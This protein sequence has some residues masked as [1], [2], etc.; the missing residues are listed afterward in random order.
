MADPSD[1][2]D[3]AA[4][5]FVVAW[6]R[7]DEVPDGTERL[8]LFGV[9]RRV[10]ANQRRG[11]VRRNRLADRLRDELATL[12]RTTWHDETH[13]AVQEAMLRLPDGDR[14]LL[15]LAAWEGLTPAEIAILEGLPPATV[16]SRLLRA[17]G[18]LRELLREPVAA[19]MQRGS[20]DGHV[21]GGAP[22]NDPT[23]RS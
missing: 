18:R 10:L 23:N 1:A 15:Q 20:R 22:S 19:G 17:R 2:A 14:E 6:R 21:S 9:A 3:V 12:P 8:W 5:V 7:L 16:R 11:Q 13:A 4:D